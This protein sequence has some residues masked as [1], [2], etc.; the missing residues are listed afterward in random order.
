VADPTPGTWTARILWA[1]GRAHLQSPPNVPGTFTGDVSFRVTGQ[2]FVTSP[3]LSPVTIPAHASV[4]VPLSVRMPRTP[5]DHAESV[6]L[7]AGNGAVTSLPITRRTLIPSAGGRFDTTI[8]STVG[9]GVGQISTYDID[10][11]PGQNDIEP[12]SRPR[13]RAP[14]TGSLT[15]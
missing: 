7:V 2:Q 5:G 13:T 11:P 15:S 1:N 3:A 9:R 8:T 4:T 12:A 14:T 6:Q 10:V